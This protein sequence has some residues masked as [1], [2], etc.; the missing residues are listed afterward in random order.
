MFLLLLRLLGYFYWLT[1][2]GTFT[3]SS[4]PDTSYSI[5]TFSNTIYLRSS[6]HQMDDSV[7][8]LG[9]LA[10]AGF[11]YYYYNYMKT[12]TDRLYAAFGGYKPNVFL[13][14]MQ[15]NPGAYDA[16]YSDVISQ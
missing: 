1:S 7:K 15:D 9:V 16:E 3:T 4:N 6:P 5:L 11:A 13:S 12:P 8:M 10:L 14:K 2:F